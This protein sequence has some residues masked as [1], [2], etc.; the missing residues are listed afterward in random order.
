MSSFQTNFKG[1]RE[2][3]LR[4]PTRGKMD[5]FKQGVGEGFQEVGAVHVGGRC[6][7]RPR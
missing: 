4:G 5:R 1:F 6:K 2:F 3:Y 7:V